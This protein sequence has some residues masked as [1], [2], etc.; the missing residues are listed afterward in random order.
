MCVH[1]QKYKLDHQIEAQDQQDKRNLNAQGRNG[2]QMQVER[3]QAAAG[4][5]V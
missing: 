1:A 5:D 3:R 2:W 4:E